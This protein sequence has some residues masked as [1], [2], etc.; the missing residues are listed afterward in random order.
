MDT[1]GCYVALRPVLG[2]NI[3]IA[4]M[5]EGALLC[6]SGAQHGLVFPS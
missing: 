1:A 3:N 4:G 6:G 5:G 2:A